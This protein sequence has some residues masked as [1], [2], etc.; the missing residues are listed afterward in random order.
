MAFIEDDLEDDDQQQLGGGQAPLVGGGSNAAGTGVSQAGV[1]AGGTGGWTNIQAYLNANKGDTG[2]SQALQSE[3]GEQ[4]NKE[5]DAFKTDSSKFLSDAEKQLGESKVTGDQAGEMVKQGAANYDWGGQQKTAYTD[6]VNKIQ[7]FLTND[8]KG[9]KSYDYGFNAQTQNYG[10]AVK[11]DSQGFDSL[12]NSIQSKKANAPLTSGQ[13]QLQKQLDVNN[14]NLVNTRKQLGQQ[15]EGLTAERDNVVKDTT[16]KL[17]GYEQDYRTG[18]NALRDYLTNQSGDYDTKIAQQEGAAKSEY[19]KLFKEGKT[20]NASIGWER[21]ISG[22]N[23]T[24]RA[25]LGIFGDNLSWSQLEKENS[26]ITPNRGF[27]NDTDTEHVGWYDYNRND[28]TTQR[29]LDRRRSVLDGFYGEQDAK[30]ANVAD[31]DERA[32]NTIMDFLG[33]TGER[34]KKGFSVRS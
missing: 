20:G 15:Y 26:A 4:F 14:E 3:V 28:G 7:G 33:A 6:N 23:A 9:P 30:Y 24:D 34:K 16:Q 13:Y 22:V 25:N 12:M 11:G 27:W 31:E 8:Y 32:Y 10:S 5:R 2:S 17:G 21:G 18:Q 19:D 1:G 29:E